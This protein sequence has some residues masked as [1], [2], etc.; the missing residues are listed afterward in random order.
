MEL[1]INVSF[2]GLELARQKKAQEEIWALILGTWWVS[3]SWMAFKATS[4]SIGPRF[5]VTAF[6]NCSQQML[7]FYAVGIT[8][9]HG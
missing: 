6:S 9:V 7:G 4:I 5:L 3:L 8:T 1:W 2:I